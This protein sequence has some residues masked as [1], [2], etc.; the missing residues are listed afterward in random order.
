M[1]IKRYYYFSKKYLQLKKYQITGEKKPITCMIS[2]TSNCNSGCLTCNFWQ[3]RS[4]D[5]LTLDEIKKIFASPVMSNLK[6]IGITG[7]EPTLRPD[8]GEIIKAVHELTG[9]KPTLST[10]GWMPQKVDVLL[11]ENGKIIRNVGTSVD[12]LEPTH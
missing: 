9:V 2:V 3:L 4:K 10:N 1:S 12:G 7:G 5:E 8:L 11:K 6:N